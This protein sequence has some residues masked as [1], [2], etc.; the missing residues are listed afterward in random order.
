VSATFSLSEAYV[1]ARSAPDVEALLYDTQHHKYPGELIDYSGTRGYE[2]RGKSSS[3]S[4][5][6]SSSSDESSSS[7]DEDSSGN[8]LLR[9]HDKHYIAKRQNQRIGFTYL[10]DT[11]NIEVVPG[12]ENLVFNGYAQTEKKNNR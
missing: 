9:F 2:E 6:S 11:R 12:E 5:D 7:S 10:L 4:D 8:P 1:H 3:S